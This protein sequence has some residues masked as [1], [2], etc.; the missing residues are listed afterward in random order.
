M[1][2]SDHIFLL[3]LLADRGVLIPT[4]ELLS[5]SKQAAAKVVLKTIQKN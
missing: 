3:V 5:E 4:D 1:K 2:L